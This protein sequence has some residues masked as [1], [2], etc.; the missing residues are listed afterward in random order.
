MHYVSDN[1][2][3]TLSKTGNAINNLPLQTQNYSLDDV[4]KK[5]LEEIKTLLKKNDRSNR[6]QEFMSQVNVQAFNLT[7]LENGFKNTLARNKSDVPVIFTEP[8]IA[9]DEINNFFKTCSENKMFPSIASFCAYSGVS[10]EEL[11][12]YASRPEISPCAV[13]LKEF[14]N[15]CHS[16]LENATLNDKVDSR[17]YSILASNYYDMKSQSTLYVAPALENKGNFAS[18]SVEVIKEQMKLTSPK[19]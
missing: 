18:Q 19:D 3:N 2:K 8:S 9:V 16:M 10:K 6:L 5:D 15:Q 14:I 17:L 13:I 12:Y 11:F 4:G 1:I 7:L